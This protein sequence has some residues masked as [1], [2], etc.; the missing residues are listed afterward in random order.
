MTSLTGAIRTCFAQSHKQIVLCQ[1]TGKPSIIIKHGK[2]VLRTAE[3]GVNCLIEGRL[4][5]Q[6]YRIESS[7]R[8]TPEYPT[9]R[10][11]FARMMIHF[12]RP[13]K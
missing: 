3:Q 8:S 5:I 7:S 4:M 6:A 13:Y 1:Q 2:F 10:N 12:L 11:A 9:S